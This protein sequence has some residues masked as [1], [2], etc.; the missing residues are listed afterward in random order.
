MRTNR[1]S[2]RGRAPFRTRFGQAGTSSVRA[3]H[4]PNPPGR[5]RYRFLASPFFTRGSG[6]K[7]A[8]VDV[9]RLVAL[10]LGVAGDVAEQRAHRGLGRRRRQASPAHLR[11]R[12][13][14]G[15]Q[16]DRRAFDIA[17]A[18][19]DLP[20]EADVRRCDFSR[21]WRSSSVGELM[22]VLRWIPPSRAN[23]AFS[24]PGMVRKMPHLL[25]MLEL[26]L[27]ADHVPQR[28]EL[29]VLPQLDHGI[30]PAPGRVGLSSP[31]A[32]IGP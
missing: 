32:F 19:G 1:G 12:Q 10:G 18:A 29:V 5:A 14:A 8:E 31:T 2:A 25:G 7:Q 21:S 23:S 28:A 11:H 27:E 17:L 4:S 3:S 6:G 15:E 13:A 9:H 24:S 20:G 16:A 26:G 30:G 22:K